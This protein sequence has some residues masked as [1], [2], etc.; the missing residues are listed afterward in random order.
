ME[1][2]IARVEVIGPEILVE[3]PELIADEE[4]L[5]DHLG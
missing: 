1:D 4:A 5:V 3:A 2:G